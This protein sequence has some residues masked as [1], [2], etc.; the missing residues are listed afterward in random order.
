M[1]LPN[2]ASYIVLSSGLLMAKEVE[3]LVQGQNKPPRTVK[4]LG[5]LHHGESTWSNWHPEPEEN[6]ENGVQILRYLEKRLWSL[7]LKEKVKE[8]GLFIHS[9]VQQLHIEHLL[10]SDAVLSPR[11][12]LANWMVIG[13]CRKLDFNSIR[14]A[15]LNIKSYPKMDWATLGGDE[16]SN[17][18]KVWKNNLNNR[19]NW[20]G[21][22]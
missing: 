20:P 14:K 19:L 3:E 17:F 22:F 6:V 15:S 5:K 13:S 1:L 21:A 8:R 10:H 18:E 2:D 9:F 16:F 12:T 7:W 11:D 4:D